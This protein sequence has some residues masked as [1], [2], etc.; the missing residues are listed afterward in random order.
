MRNSQRTH[1]HFGGV[2][3]HQLAA[4]LLRDEPALRT[5]LEFGTF[6]HQGDGPDAALI[7]GDQAEIPLLRGVYESRRDYRMALLAKPSDAVIVRKRDTAYEHYLDTHLGIADVIYL[8]AREASHVPIAVNALG[9]GALGETLDMIATSG[10]SFTLKPYLTTQN[11]WRLARH[12]GE[13]AQRDMFVSGPS[14]RVSRRVND[15]LWFSDL[16]RQLFGRDA[17]PPSMAGYSLA[18]AAAEMAYL[19]EQSERVVAKVPDSAGSAGNIMFRSADLRGKSLATLETLLENRLHA[20]GWTDRFPL[21]IGIWERHV[22]C[23][24][25]VQL[26]IP[27]RADGPPV[28]EGVFEQHTRNAEAAFVGATISRLPDAVQDDL[29]TE[30]VTIATVLQKLGYYGRC[31]FDAVVV[32][33]PGASPAIHWIECNGRWGGVSIPMTLAQRLK[34]G[35]LP[36]GFLVVQEYRSDMPRMGTASCLTRLGDLLYRK[37]RQEAGLILTAPP[38]AADGMSVSLLA[39]GNAPGQVGLLIK[40]AFKR[41]RDETPAR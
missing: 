33:P 23:S 41:L 19:A 15:K 31:S 2:P 22:Q 11:T 9:E 32:Q 39:I 28:A 38:T 10:I 26:W 36:Q 37:G 34:G 25:S 4:Q 8:E 21:L 1:R 24:P 35:R 16:T 3:P 5:S 27:G 12:L 13:V 30:A 14:P 7:I 18:A 29:G 6:V 17:T 40:E 20:T